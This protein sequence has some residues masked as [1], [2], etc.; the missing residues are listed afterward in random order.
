MGELFLRSEQP[1]ENILTNL[2]GLRRLNV[3]DVN[4][5]CRDGTVLAHKI[6]LASVSQMLQ[7]VFSGNFL[8]EKISILAPDVDRKSV[9]RC[10]DELYNHGKVSKED[11][12]INLIM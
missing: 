2:L 12:F 10:L 1:L 7:F 9:S 6:I 3:G 11:D 4:I 8:D 5:V